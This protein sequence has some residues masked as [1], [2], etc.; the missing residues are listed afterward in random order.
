MDRGNVLVIMSGLVCMTL[1]VCATI[2]FIIVGKHSSPEMHKAAQDEVTQRLP[3]VPKGP[4]PGYIPTGGQM[5]APCTVDAPERP[6]EAPPSPPA[7]GGAPK[8]PWVKYEAQ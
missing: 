5:K 7:T 8:G 6:T 1:T 2:A 4:A 3:K